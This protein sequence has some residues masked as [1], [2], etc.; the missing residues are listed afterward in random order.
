MAD[1]LG[2]RLQTVCGYGIMSITNMPYKDPEK[3]KEYQKKWMAKRREAWR[4]GKRCI[5][6][7]SYEDIQLDHKDPS[8][9]VSHRIWSW[10]LTR[11][12]AEI[13]KC[14]PLCRKCH[15]IKT[16]L[17]DTRRQPCG[18]SASYN[19]GCRCD[20]CKKAHSIYLSDYRIKTGRKMPPTLL[21]L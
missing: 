14:Q 20:E 5:Q 4:S 19:R 3:Q 10:S 13:A 11:R 1:W 2:T 17:L 8:Q 18:T 21:P 12:E 7:G 9:K 15:R 6:C 16:S